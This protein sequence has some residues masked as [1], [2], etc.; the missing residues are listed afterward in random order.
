[1]GPVISTS[2]ER[3]PVSPRSNRLAWLAIRKV[4]GSVAPMRCMTGTSSPARNASWARMPMNT[5]RPRATKKNWL[6]GVPPSFLASSLP[7]STFQYG[8]TCFSM[9]SPSATSS[10]RL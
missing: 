3:P 6:S 2:M 5:W 7:G 1:M 9:V 8:A 4:P 10:S